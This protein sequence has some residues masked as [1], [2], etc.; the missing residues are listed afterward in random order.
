[1][2]RIAAAFLVACVGRAAAATAPAGEARIDRPIRIE[3][4][5]VESRT[6]LWDP[7]DSMQANLV[8][9]IS[10]RFANRRDVAA[11]RLTFGLRY[12]GSAESI[13]EN[14][15]FAPGTMVDRNLPAFVGHPY[16]GASADCCV[17][18]AE[19]ADGTTWE[20][21]RVYICSTAR[22][23]GTSSRTAR[24]IPNLSVVMA[25][26]QPPHAPTIWT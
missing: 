9:G 17:Q 13:V 2:P 16:A 20:E 15:T 7:F 14:G 3:R 6:F 24:S 19:F 25:A 10:I 5:A 18:S 12:A 8:S 11:T 26:A 1:V 4:C 23:S 21:V 22:I